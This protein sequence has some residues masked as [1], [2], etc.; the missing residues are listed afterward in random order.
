[1][2]L[3][4]FFKVIIGIFFTESYFR[5]I[6]C[7]FF[8]LDW[9]V[10][11]DEN[12]LSRSFKI[13]IQFRFTFNYAFK[14]TKAFQ[15]GLSEI[16]DITIVRLRDFAEHFNFF[17]MVCTHFHHCQFMLPLNGKQRKRNSD[18][19]IEIPEGVL[20]VIFP[21]QNRMYDLFRCRFPVA[22][23]KRNNRNFYMITVKGRQFL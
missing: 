18:V 9:I 8:R 21:G 13:I 3:R 7:S 22:A 5:R 17:L 10:F 14:T 4:K 23:G 1:M 6:V 12:G 11:V 15:V 2:I 16:R 19:V 20:H